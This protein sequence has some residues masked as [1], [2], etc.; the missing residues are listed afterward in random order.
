VKNLY[1]ENYESLKKEIDDSRR[2]KEL[3]YSRISRIN[4]IKVVIHL[5]SICIVKV[6][7][8]KIAISYFTEIEKSILKF[9]WKNKT[10]KS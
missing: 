1:N 9:F 2:W 6:M 7:S 10:Q 8:I 3:S 4:I 5:K